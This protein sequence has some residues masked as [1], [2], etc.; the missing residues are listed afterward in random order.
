MTYDTDNSELE[1]DVR[2]ET[3]DLVDTAAWTSATSYYIY[4][5]G[6]L[7]KTRFVLERDDSYTSDEVYTV[8]GPFKGA[9]VRT[10]TD[11]ANTES[12]DSFVYEINA[13]RQVT[14]FV[15]T[16]DNGIVT[17]LTY[18][19]DGDFGWATRSRNEDTA[20][21]FNWASTDRLLNASGET[22]S[23]EIEYD[24]GVNVLNEYD[25]DAAYAWA[26]KVTRTEA[27]GAVTEYFYDDDG[28]L[29]DTVLM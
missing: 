27:D 3:Q 20:D 15:R 17:T 18:D 19:R 22:M 25:L 29:Y 24:N 28:L 9:S 13:A 16:N 8:Q 12:W 1:W 2:S 26:R 4:L 21:I 5:N 7:A 6:G 10:L 11:A 14:E 23:F